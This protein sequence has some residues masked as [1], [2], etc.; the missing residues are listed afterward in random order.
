[1]REVIVRNV[2]IGCHVCAA[3]RATTNGAT[4]F[5]AGVTSGM[6]ADELRFCDEHLGG[7]KRATA[8]FEKPRS[9]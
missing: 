6:L 5:I 9:T 3:L 2:D 7:L 8:A 4:L 1:M